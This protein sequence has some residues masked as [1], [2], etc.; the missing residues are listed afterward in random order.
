MIDGATSQLIAQA[1]TYSYIGLFGVGFLANIFVPVPEEVVLLVLGYVVG[2]GKFLFLP[3]VGVVLLG[4]LLSDVLMYELSF[5]G[6]K[7]LR[8]IYDRLFGKIIPM[9]EEF[10]EKH[11]EKIIFISRFLIQLRFLGPF[12]A[13][14]IKYPRK[15]FIQYNVLALILYIPLFVW[16][17]RYFQN[18]IEYVIDGVG[19]VKNILLA[20]LIVAVLVVTV[21]MI[22]TFV[23]RYYAKVFSSGERST[24]SES[25]DR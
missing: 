7:I 3:T 8:A 19:Q 13:G 18:R 24:L 5:R 12:L 21:K 2:T 23:L 15:K 9:R 20:V 11:I 17:G 4:A 16:V 1:S 6:N 14:R 22:R 25:E 10:I